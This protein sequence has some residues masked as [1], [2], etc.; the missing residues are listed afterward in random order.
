MTLWPLPLRDAPPETAGDAP[1]A[2]RHRRWDL[3]AGAA[4]LLFFLAMAGIGGYLQRDSYLLRSP[5][6]PLEARWM[7]HAG[8]GTPFAVAVAVLVVAY[9][10][11]LAARLP[12]RALL[13]SAWAV[14][15]AWTWALALVDGWQR[16]VAGRLTRR[17]EYLAGVRRFDDLGPAL[18]GFTGHIL[19]HSPD[20]WP[21]HIAGHPAGAVLTFVGLDRIG[22]GGGAVAGTFCITAGTSL[23][24]AILLTLRVLTGEERARAAAPFVVLAPGAVWVGVSADGYFAAVAAWALALLAV[25]ATRTSPVRTAVAGLGSGLLFGAAAYLS[26]GLVLLVVPAAAILLCTRT[27]R[28]LPYLVLGVVAV[29]AAFT[30]AGFNWWE[31]YG[32]L[33]TRYYQGYGGIRPYRYWFFGDL[34][35]V[36]ATAGV[37]S[38]AG[39]RRA[40]AA[41]PRA[42]RD[43]RQH[44]APALAAVLLPC[45]FLLAILAA[46]V[47][48][49]SKA[50]TER[51]WLPFALWLTSTAAFLPHR[52]HRRWLA[53]Q[54]LAALLVNHLLL[55]VW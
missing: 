19:L 28:P 20:N 46:D 52:D 8:P 17:S 36:V 11:S 2:P 48:G 7:P 26:Y 42:L 44:N 34:A 54:A 35:T 13:G 18:R 29:V 33:R 32:L 3:A 47:S 51:I 53:A 38:V 24:A 39:L 14:A 41:A 10:P 9:G 21:T 49:L 31:A 16:G 12:W 22:L 27:L 25:A 15:M 37:A 1:D 55:T 23:A 30:A 4:G 50:E 6:P 43:G 5:F 40:L 45:G